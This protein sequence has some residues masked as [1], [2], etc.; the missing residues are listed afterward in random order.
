MC[1]KLGLKVRQTKDPND[2]LT[3]QEKRDGVQLV[4]FE[5]GGFD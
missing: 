2:S 1:K 3:E 4:L 5:S